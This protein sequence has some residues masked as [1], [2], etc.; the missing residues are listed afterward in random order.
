MPESQS[1]FSQEYSQPESKVGKRFAHLTGDVRDSI[2]LVKIHSE[3]SMSKPSP[4]K[5]LMHPHL[6]KIKQAF[7]RFKQT[8]EAI[9]KNQIRQTE[10][11][12]VDRLKMEIA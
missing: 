7:E 10:E 11:T 3:K 6:D 9:V 8:H 1:K 5:K 2:D 12:E 4:D